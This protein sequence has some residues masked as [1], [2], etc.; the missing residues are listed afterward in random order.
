[1]DGCDVTVMDEEKAVVASVCF[2]RRR[3]EEIRLVEQT[4]V[5]G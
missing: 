2:L 3:E 4:C 1:M 5:C